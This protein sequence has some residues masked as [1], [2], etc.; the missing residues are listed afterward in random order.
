[1][2]N[3]VHTGIVDCAALLIGVEVLNVSVGHS[4]LLATTAPMYSTH[5]SIIIVL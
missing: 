5:K 1:M 3:L 4:C 2:L